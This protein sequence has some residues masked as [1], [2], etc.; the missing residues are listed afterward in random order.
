MN[1]DKLLSCGITPPS[2]C[3]L[4]YASRL[5]ANDVS[6]KISAPDPALAL[7]DWAARLVWG[8]EDEDVSEFTVEGANFASCAPTSEENANI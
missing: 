2:E 1:V 3:L 8:A 7:D 6:S 4:I 5:I